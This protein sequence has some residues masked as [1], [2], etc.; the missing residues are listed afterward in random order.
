[1][2]ASVRAMYLLWTKPIAPVHNKHR[3]LGRWCGDNQ[4]VQHTCPGVAPTAFG[5]S[6]RLWHREEDEQSR[7]SP[8]RFHAASA[9]ST[10]SCAKFGNVFIY[11]FWCRNLA[12]APYTTA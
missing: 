11:T 12:F 10:V 1:M 5:S 4:H 2:A 7:I 6:H 9:F 8:V 3:Q